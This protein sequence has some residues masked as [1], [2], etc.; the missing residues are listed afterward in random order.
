MPS[1]QMTPSHLAEQGE[2]FGSHDLNVFTLVKDFLSLRRASTSDKE[3]EGGGRKQRRRR[4]KRRRTAAIADPEMRQVPV[5]TRRCSERL[6]LC[7]SRSF[8]L[9]FFFLFC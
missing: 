3:R 6:L 4:R 5:Q 7:G 9:V 1:K 8:C 2:E